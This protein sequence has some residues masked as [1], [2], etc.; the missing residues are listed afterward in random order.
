MDYL[1]EILTANIYDLCIETPLNK[2]KY[3]SEYCGLNVLLKREDL[4]PIFSFKLRGAYNK[5][6]SLTKEQKKA[7]VIAC[8]AGILLMILG[9][10][11]Q[12]VGNQ[13]FSC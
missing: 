11:A 10:H 2:A 3:L 8:S 4:Q 9:N 6:L 1:K 12:G 5:I 13:L 7:G